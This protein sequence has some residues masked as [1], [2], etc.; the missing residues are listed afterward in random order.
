[1]P[2]DSDEEIVFRALGLVYADWLRKLAAHNFRTPL[3]EMKSMIHKRII[4][5][6]KDLGDE[7]IT[8]PI[9]GVS[10]PVIVHP[11]KLTLER[12]PRESVDVGRQVPTPTKAK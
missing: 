9:A 5:A 8:P 11:E 2:P 12:E 4:G 10:S 1:M 3:D 7:R 6:T